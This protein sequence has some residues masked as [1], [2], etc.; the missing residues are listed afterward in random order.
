MI[1]LPLREFLKS[2]IFI[3]LRLLRL[4]LR[5]LIAHPAFS[6]DI[7]VRVPENQVLRYRLLQEP[8]QLPSMCRPRLLL[9]PLPIPTLWFKMSCLQ[10][11]WFPRPLLLIRSPLPLRRC[12][13]PTVLSKSQPQPL[14]SL[15]LERISC[16]N[17]S[18]WFYHPVRSL[19]ASWLVFRSAIWRSDM[20]SSSL[21]SQLELFLQHQLQLR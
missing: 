3:R 5:F 6:R 8:L 15:H 2:K 11:L 9:S 20:L 16:R 10:P 17:M 12:R 13:T 14:V 18:R 19:H 4:H 7:K 21:A 1:F